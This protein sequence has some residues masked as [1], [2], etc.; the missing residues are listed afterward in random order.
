MFPSLLV[1]VVVPRRRARRGPSRGCRRVDLVLFSGPCYATPGKERALAAA[2]AA[3]G[4]RL[5]PVASR[6]Y[7]IGGL[8]AR[9]APLALGH[10]SSRR[11]GHPPVPA[12]PA[13]P[14]ARSCRLRP[15][16]PVR[17]PADRPRPRGCAARRHP[18][19]R[20]ESVPAL[21]AALLDEHAPDPPLLIA[22]LRRAGPVRLL[23]LLA[24]P[25]WSE[26]ARVLAA[27]C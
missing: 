9:N 23:E 24:V 6:V 27:W 7:A 15:R 17:P 5:R 3:R 18:A 20:R 21:R 12:T 14:C 26:D 8:D 4:R 11:R 1:G 16:R 19:R 2:E 22:V 25:P 13:P 10:G